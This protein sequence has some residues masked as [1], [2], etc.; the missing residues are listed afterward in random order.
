[1]RIQLRIHT[2]SLW[3]AVELR[4]VW[5]ESGFA[6]SVSLPLMRLALRI[7]TDDRFVEGSTT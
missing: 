2:H 7:E 5:N 4:F 1:M 3:Q 6:A